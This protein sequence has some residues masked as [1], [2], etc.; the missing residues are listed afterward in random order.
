MLCN[1]FQI[2]FEPCYKICHNSG[3]IVS[4]EKNSSK[5]FIVQCDNDTD[6]A[7]SLTEICI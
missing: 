3:F 4:A 1:V 2:E 6:S 5:A 7:A